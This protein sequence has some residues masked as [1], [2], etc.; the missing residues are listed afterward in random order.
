MLV[1]EYSN[2]DVFENENFVGGVVRSCIDTALCGLAYIPLIV[3]NRRSQKSHLC[4]YF[5]SIVATSSVVRCDCNFLAFVDV[6]RVDLFS[7]LLL[8][9]MCPRS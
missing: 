3:L 4:E 6:L 1:A 9:V 5:A 8:P 2:D 7:C